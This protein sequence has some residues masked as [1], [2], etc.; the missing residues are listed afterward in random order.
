VVVFSSLHLIEFSVA[1][2]VRDAESR[3]RAL[4]RGFEQRTLAHL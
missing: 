1:A 4:A 3:S 2:L